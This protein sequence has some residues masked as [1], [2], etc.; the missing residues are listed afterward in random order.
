MASP[1]WEHGTLGDGTV[2]NDDSSTGNEC[3]GTNMY[4]F[5]NDYTNDDNGAYSTS[6]VT[7]SMEWTLVHSSLVSLVG[8]VCI[9][10]CQPRC[11]PN[12]NLLRLWIHYGQKLISTKQL[13]TVDQLSSWRYIPFDVA[14]S[15]GVG[16][17]NGLYPVG[18]GNGKIQSCDTLSGTDYAL[19]GES[20]H[21]TLN[22]DGWA[23]MAVNLQEH[24]GKYVH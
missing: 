15:S 17:V 20:T 16:Y 9:G 14:N 6:L 13:P 19:G 8:T 5:D 22:P 21:P 10:T 7:P 23:E 3:W 24:A 2:L 1:G 4:D 11:K 18:F 12:Q